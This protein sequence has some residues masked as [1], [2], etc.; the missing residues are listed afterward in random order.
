MVVCQI[1]IRFIIQEDAYYPFGMRMNGLC[2]ETGLD[3]KNKYLYNGKELQDEFGL[4]WY[5]YR[6]RFYDA[7]LGRWHT[8]DPLVEEYFKWSPFNY[9]LNN[10]IKFI[11]PDGSFVDGYKNLQDEYKWY[12]NETDKL[13]YKDDH[14]WFKVADNKEHFDLFKSGLL[15]NIPETCDLGEITE[16]DKLSSFEMWLDSPSESIGEGI[17]KIGAIIGYSLVNSPYSLLTGQTIGGTSLN[18]SE[19]MDAFVDFVPGLITGGLTKTGQ[20]VKTTKKGL[21]GFNKFVKNTPG[22]TTTKGLPK[23][24]SWQTRAGQLFQTNK[25]NQQGLKDL[26]KARNVLNIV[27]TT[28]KEI[29]K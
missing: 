29:E 23:R 5:D 28:N 6:A 12:D 2:Y 17:G 20:V 24:I 27:N 4:D 18:S 1:N 13:V 19:K 25:V 11:D 26:D 14:F 9:A 21:Q 16:A 10:P 15:D 8:P 3:Y 22:I 7:Q